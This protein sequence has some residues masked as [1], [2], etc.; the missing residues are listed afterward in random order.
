[1]DDGAMSIE[2]L[3]RRDER[4]TF[5]GSAAV[6]RGTHL[7]RSQALGGGRHSD[8]DQRVAARLKPAGGG[9]ARLVARVCP[10]AGDRAA[11]PLAQC[12]SISFSTVH[13]T[14]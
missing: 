13:L 11:L 7:S 5:G 1:M 2:V 10:W 3:R 12:A 6:R 9:G 14:D 4:N 8:R